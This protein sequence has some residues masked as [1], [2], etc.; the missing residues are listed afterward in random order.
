MDNLSRTAF[1]ISFPQ[2]VR[3]V[4]QPMGGNFHARMHNSNGKHLLANLLVASLGKC[5]PLSNIY[6]GIYHCKSSEKFFSVDV[7]THTKGQPHTDPTLNKYTVC[8]L[9]DRVSWHFFK[10][11]LV[12][13]LPNT[14]IAT[15]SLATKGAIYEKKQQ[16]R[17]QPVLNVLW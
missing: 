10:L 9:T 3:C 15:S 14:A 11:H 5:L 2:F 13:P 12:K 4:I 7:T 6:S 1:G 8:A 17:P 16:P